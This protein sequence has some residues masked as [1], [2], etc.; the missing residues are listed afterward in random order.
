MVFVELVFLEKSFKQITD[1]I[2]GFDDFQSVI[3]L[4]RRFDFEIEYFVNWIHE[5]EEGWFWRS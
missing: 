4:D 5:G 1:A 2:P 3:Q